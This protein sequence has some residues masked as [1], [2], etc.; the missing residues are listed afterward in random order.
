MILPTTV[1]WWGVE[2]GKVTNAI[3]QNHIRIQPFQA[4]AKK[5]RDH[6]SIRR[7]T[8]VMPRQGDR[9]GIDQRLLAAAAAAAAAAAKRAGRRDGGSS[10]TTTTTT[11]TTP[12]RTIKCIRIDFY[13]T[14]TSTSSSGSSSVE[15]I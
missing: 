13:E 5:G 1:G 7:Q 8:A 12:S 3:S 9:R 14:S 10:T 6:S 4:A 2:A 15:L 11:R